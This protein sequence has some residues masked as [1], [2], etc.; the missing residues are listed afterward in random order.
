M[1][2]AS[3]RLGLLI[4]PLLITVVVAGC[5]GTPGTSTSIPETAT[6]TVAAA[7]APE[8]G[9]DSGIT[10]TGNVGD[11]PAITVPKSDPPEDLVTEVL[12]KG[13]G[14]VVRSGQY[15]VTDYLG[16]TWK[17]VDGKASVFDNSY[18]YGAVSGFLIGTGAVIKG[19]DKAL[20]G[21]HV[22]SRVLLVV[23]PALGYGATT[24][25][26]NDLAGH[27]LVFVVDI[28]AAVDKDAAADGTPTGALSAGM[29]GVSSEP[30]KQPTITSVEGV[31]LG[32]KARS[33]LLLTGTGAELREDTMFLLQITRIDTAT[34]NEVEKTWG[35][36]PE[37]VPA[38]EVFSLL[39]ALKGHKVGSR[40]VSITPNLDGSLSMVIVVDVIGQY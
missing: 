28:L 14:A 11:K 40:A 13:T 33:E 4:V 34:R 25:P 16:Q 38:T 1:N 9:T 21:Q 37:L 12:V 26:N 17:L 3:H 22:G 32:A 35:K 8:R 10:V 23:P 39:P 20:V 2:L 24:S 30:G 31:T 7:T 18:D 36:Q 29:P 15:L 27:T 6:P 5:S 19:W